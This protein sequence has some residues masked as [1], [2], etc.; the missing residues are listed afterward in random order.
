MDI[1][2]ELIESDECPHLFLQDPLIEHLPTL[3]ALLIHLPGI[4]AFFANTGS[5]TADDLI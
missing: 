5:S 4:T 1:K 2:K 3:D